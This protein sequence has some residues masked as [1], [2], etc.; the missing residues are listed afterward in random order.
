MKKVLLVGALVAAIGLPVTLSAQ[1]VTLSRKV[2]AD[3]QPLA[4]GT[5]TVRLTGDQPKPGVGQTPDSERYVEFLRGGKVVGKEVATVVANAD[6]KDVVKGPRPPAG[7]SR[8]DLLKGND[9]VRITI[10]RGGIF[11]LIHLPVAA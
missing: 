9:Y 3:G 7:E 2:M 4:A 6:A 1:N 11:Y 5:Y 10:N 8:V